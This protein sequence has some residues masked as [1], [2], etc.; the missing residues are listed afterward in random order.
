[1]PQDRLRVEISLKDWPD[2]INDLRK[3]MAQLVREHAER[4]S[5]EVR[6][7]LHDIADIFESGIPPEAP[8][9]T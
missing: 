1:M 7:V 8:E 5:P 3:E 2:L 9:E 4:E 6:R